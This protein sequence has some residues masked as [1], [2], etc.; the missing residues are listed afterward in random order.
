MDIYITVKTASRRKGFLTEKLFDIPASPSTLKDLLTE[1]TRIVYHQYASQAL[2]AD[3]VAALTE[4]DVLDGRDIGKVGF[5]RRFAE[6]GTTFDAAEA[7]M[8]L[9]FEDGLFR[10]F[11]N[12]EEASVLADRISLKDGD[13][14]LLVRLTMLAGSY[15]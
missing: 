1:I 9:A 2:D 4:R 15:F 13:Q 5:G 3:I 11:L 8:L 14:V 6:G 10:V 7:A 12:G